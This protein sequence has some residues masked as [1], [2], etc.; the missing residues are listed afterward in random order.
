MGSP[1]VVDLERELAYLWPDGEQGGY[2]LHDGNDNSQVIYLSLTHWLFFLSVTGGDFGL[3]LYFGFGFDFWFFLEREGRR[4]E[5]QR[6]ERESEKNG[7]DEKNKKE[8][9]WEE[10][11]R[12]KIEEK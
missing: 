6:M 4:G 5:R 10:W 9:E 1:K 8:R 12:K 3:K 11:I 7:E 2:S